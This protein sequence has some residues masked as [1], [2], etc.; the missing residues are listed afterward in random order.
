[1]TEIEIDQHLNPSKYW[2]SDERKEHNAPLQLALAKTE[3]D[4]ASEVLRGYAD[5]IADSDFGEGETADT[6][7]EA[8]I[9]G[10]ITE[11][12]FV[13]ILKQVKEEMIYLLRLIIY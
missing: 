13:V 10:Q 7:E 12:H 4:R 8:K 2:S 9:Y 3:Y 1:M 11:S 6:L 5:Q